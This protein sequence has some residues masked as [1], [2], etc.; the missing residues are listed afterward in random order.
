MEAERWQ[1]IEKLY[2]RALDCPS[3]ERM[4]FLAQACAGDRLLEEE[5]VTLLASH[6]AAGTFLAQPALQMAARDEIADTA[7]LSN[8]SIEEQTRSSPQRL[9]GNYELLGELG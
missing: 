4:A 1:Q 5:I 9:V 7:P 2:Y 3:H 6:E 8:A